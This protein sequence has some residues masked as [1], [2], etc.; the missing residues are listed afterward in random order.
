MSA[1]LRLLRKQLIKPRIGCMFSSASSVIV[2]KLPWETSFDNHDVGGLN[3]GGW[4]YETIVK[5][6]NIPQA[7][8]G[9][10]ASE[11]MPKNHVICC[12]KIINMAELNEL[13]S[14]TSLIPSNYS[15]RVKNRTE[16]NQLIEI[17]M[18]YFEESYDNILKGI[19]HF[20]T[21]HD[22]TYSSV[23]LYSQS[24][25][26]NHDNDAN[27]SWVDDEAHNYFWIISLKDIQK[28]D[29]I[30]SDYH[31]IMLPK[32]YID[33]YKDAKLSGLVT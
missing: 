13:I 15:I 29:E 3:D 31:S 22:P 27:A 21:S 10:F 2:K 28:G 4:S 12:K 32:F 5:K 23:Q 30:T 7:G 11:Y 19:Q 20:M 25:H 24:T 8:H 9:R 18:C 17:F 33:F 14:T 1:M 26:T 6:S 16:L